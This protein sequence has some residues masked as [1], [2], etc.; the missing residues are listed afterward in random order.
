[1]ND[2]VNTMKKTQ[3]VGLQILIESDNSK[4]TSCTEV[5]CDIKEIG[6]LLH[7]MKFH[8]DSLAGDMPN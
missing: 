2:S 8:Q 5:S 4:M 6:F 1:M 3:R 7:S